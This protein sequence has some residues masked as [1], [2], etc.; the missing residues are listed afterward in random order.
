MQAALA[1]GIDHAVF[2]MLLAVCRRL[3]SHRILRSTS[4]TRGIQANFRT[5]DVNHSLLGVLLAGNRG[6]TNLDAVRRLPQ[7]AFIG[8]TLASYIHHTVFCMFFTAHRG[9]AALHSKHRMLL[10]GVN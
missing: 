4:K 5:V 3:L 6:L 8:A 2:R 1:D 10:A 7:T 9:L